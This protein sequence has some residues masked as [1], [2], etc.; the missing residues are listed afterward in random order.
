MIVDF[1][2]VRLC[3]VSFRKWWRGWTAKLSSLPGRSW[4]RKKRS[5][6]YCV[7]SMRY[8]PVML[9][10]VTS[11]WCLATNIMGSQRTIGWNIPTYISKYV[12]LLYCDTTGSRLTTQHTAGTKPRPA[13]RLTAN[14]THS[15]ILLHDRLSYMPV[16]Y[17]LRGCLC[18]SLARCALSLKR[19][20]A[21]PGFN[22]QTRQN[23]LFLDYWRACFEINFSDRQEGLM[24]SSIICDFKWLWCGYGG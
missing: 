9:R 23:K 1:L 11:Y 4:S 19:L 14:V 15:F 20:S 18:G 2:A 7:C 8:D 17:G 16:F 6:K 5:F 22:P 13:L 24:V 10:L 12:E 21:G 3:L